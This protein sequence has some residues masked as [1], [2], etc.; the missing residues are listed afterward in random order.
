MKLTSAQV[1]KIFTTLEAL[2]PKD[3][4]VYHF[5]KKELVDEID[6]H[7]FAPNLNDEDL[8]ILTHL[9][10]ANYERSLVSESDKI[11]LTSSKWTDPPFM[12]YDGGPNIVLAVKEK[13]SGALYGLLV[14]DALGV[15]Y[16]FHH[17]NEIPSAE[18]IEFEPP[19]GFGR[20]HPSAP[21]GTWSDDGAQALCLLES[22]LECGQFNADDFGRRLVK[23]CDTG[24][25]TPDGQVFDIGITSSQAISALRSGVPALRAG[26]NE[27]TANGNGSLMRV[28]PL[29]LWHQGTDA[30]LVHDAE[31]QSQVTHAHLRSQVC[32][33]LYV[34]WARHLFMGTG[35]WASAVTAVREI[36]LYKP[37]YLRELNEIIEYG[38]QFGPRGTGY[39]VNTL[40]SARMALIDSGDYRETV[41]NA[42]R[43]G[44]DTDTTACVAGGIAGLRYGKQNIPEHWIA[45]LKGKEIVEPLLQ[46]LVARC[47][48]YQQ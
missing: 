18:Q 28:L 20:S 10:I 34:M 26:R 17:P 46:R 22:L 5:F 42:I 47:E 38:E 48:K 4:G 13:L 14:G 6:T 21:P 3:S 9:F 44:Q 32:C 16:E 25:M 23:W 36:Y 31:H 19:H 40:H 1:E 2:R 35:T 11:H 45:S 15:P 24:Y 37:Q 29:A 7:D 41:R 30:E 27:E 12:H 33:A 43:F 39:V 8:S